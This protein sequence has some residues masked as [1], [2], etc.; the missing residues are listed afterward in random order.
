MEQK[1][2][3]FENKEIEEATEELVAKIKEIASEMG[4]DP[5]KEV[6]LKR[7]DEDRIV[8]WPG[9]PERWVD[10]ADGEE[11]RTS[12]GNIHSIKSRTQDSFELQIKNSDAIVLVKMKES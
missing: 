8:I 11:V 3:S 10:I 1:V 2:L 12:K 9:G 5:N 6:T 4:Q 7:E